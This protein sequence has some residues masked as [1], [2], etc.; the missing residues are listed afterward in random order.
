MDGSGLDHQRRATPRA[1]ASRPGVTGGIRMKRIVLLAACVLSLGAGRA[2]ADLFVLGSDTVLR[3][4]EATGDFLGTFVPR[5]SGGLGAAR[6]LTF[7]P[8]GNLY[9][10]SQ[11]THEVLRYD[12]RTGAF[13]GAFVPARAGGLL[14][15]SGLTFGPD[16]HLY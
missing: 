9:V 6:D 1:S 4:D 3:Y 10:T 7:G 12:G 13:L 8:D 2:R 11:F 15:P 14:S 16:G 5:G